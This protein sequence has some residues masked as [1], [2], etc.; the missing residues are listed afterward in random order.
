MNGLRAQAAKAGRRYREI[1]NEPFGI[2]HCGPAELPNEKFQLVRL[3]TIEEEMGDLLEGDELM[4]VRGKGSLHQL[5]RRLR[6]P[7]VDDNLYEL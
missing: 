7:S 3:E 2:R 5:G 6:P 1:R 4:L